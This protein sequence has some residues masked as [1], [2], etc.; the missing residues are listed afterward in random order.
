MVPGDY[1]A[2]DLAQAWQRQETH[3]AALSAGR[4]GGLQKRLWIRWAA[5]AVLCLVAGGALWLYQ[6][7]RPVVVT[8]PAMWAVTASHGILHDTLADQSRVVLS[9]GS[10]LE[11]PATFTGPARM[12]QLAGEGYFTVMPNAQQPFVVAAGTVKIK[13][14][15]TAFN[16][17]SNTDSVI[18]QV[19]NGA[20]LM[21]TTS[22]SVVVKGGMQGVYQ[23]SSGQFS[24]TALSDG[25]GYAYA[26]RV[27]RFQET[28]LATV[29]SILEK[30]YDVRIVLENKALANCTI[31]T[32]FT[33]MPLTDVMEVITASLAI[34]YRMDGSVI[35]LQGNECN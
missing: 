7:R 24:V 30:A 1:S 9:A 17:R 19:D 10:R 4:T 29:V 26:T 25:N 11:R 35:Y 13:V 14:I 20:V 27:F 16:V 32:A 2:P 8:P 21:Y 15:G 6:Q 12:V 33:D 23:V 28:R 18:V 3:I 22:D 5:A 31:S 34:Q